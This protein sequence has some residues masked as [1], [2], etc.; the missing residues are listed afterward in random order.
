MSELQKIEQGNIQPVQQ[1]PMQMVSMAVEKGM[2]VA[3]IKGLMDLQERWEANEAKKAFSEAMTAFKKTPVNIEKTKQVTFENRTGDAT[4]YSHA[5]LENVSGMIG[6]AL[7]E[8]GLKHSWSTSQADGMVAVTCTIS[9]QL[10]HSESVTLSAPPDTSG[11]KNSI[12]QIASTVTYLERYTLLAATGTAVKD[13]DN[14]GGLPAAGM[15]EELLA[16]FTKRIEAK[17]SKEGAKGVYIE[18]VQVCKGFNDLNSATHLKS[19]LMAHVEKIEGIAKAEAS[20]N[21]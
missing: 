21:E 3:T 6:A 9:H 19:V 4:S 15:S 18:A 14:D 1:T 2:D 12:Q 8:H 16:D 7:A 5:T 20:E 17:T 13:Q 11:K 10:G